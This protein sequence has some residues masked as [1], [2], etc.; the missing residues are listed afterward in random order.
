MTDAVTERYVVVVNDEEQYSIWP[1]GREVPAGWRAVGRAA[2]KDECLADI[3][4]RWTDMRPLAL[5][6]AME[7]LTAVGRSRPGSTPTS[8]RNRAHTRGGRMPQAAR[9]ITQAFRGAVA[10]FPDRTAVTAPD[11]DLTYRELDARSDALAGTLLR[12]GAR[13][14][15]AGD[16]A[17][18]APHRPRRGDARQSSRRAPPTCRS[19]RSTRRPRIAWTVRDSGTANWPSS[20]PAPTPAHGRPTVPG[21]PGRHPGRGA[22]HAGRDP[23]PRPRRGRPRPRV[24]HL[25]LRVHRRPQGRP[26]GTAQRAAPVR[27]RTGAPR[28]RR[29]RRVVDV[30][31]RRVRLLRV[32]DLGPP[33][34]GRAPA[35]RP[36]EVARAPQAFRELLRTQGV[37]VLS[38]TPSAFHGLVAADQRAG[39]D[40]GRCGW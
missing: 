37:T 12:A 21:R 8:C 26:G 14:R 11:G 25:H 27:R 23:R 39:A 6:R 30:P 16:P 13:R 7:P 38:Q 20:P 19:T 18:P 31:L 4:T 2:T 40:P 9:T 5:R 24:R 29:A 33:A 35:D 22:R 3:E 15:L 17:D 28:L 34:V 1:A 32:G 36:R 10:Q